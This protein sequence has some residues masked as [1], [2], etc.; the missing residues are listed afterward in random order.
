MATYPGS[1]VS[2]TTKVNKV[3]KNDADD[4]N[5]L[6]GEV[7]AI[8]TE[9]GTDVAGSYTDLKTF[10]GVCFNTQGVVVNSTGDPGSGIVGQIFYNTDANDFKVYN[11]ATWDSVAAGTG[12]I[13]TEELINTAVTEAKIAAAAIS[14]AKLKST[15]SEVSQSGS[16]NSAMGGG[17][18]GFYPQTKVTAGN[19]DA[20]ITSTA[21][22]SI[23]TTQIHLSGTTAYAKQR[24]ITSSGKEYWV[25]L[26]WDKFA[27]KVVA[28]YQ[29]PDHP[30]YG[31]PG[32]END[33]PHP[34]LDYDAAKHEV[35]LAD[36]DFLE[37]ANKRVTR[38]R[39]LLQVINEDFT[40]HMASG[41]TYKP[42]EIIE[43][44]EF[45]DKPG[46]VLEEIV[47]PDWAKTKISKDKVCL[48]RRM[49]EKLP[50]CV[51]FKKMRK[52]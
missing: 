13:G 19:Y 29:A 47:T 9:L 28:S 44:D 24:Y 23:Y 31:T 4:I 35:V 1:L 46:E 20:V 36:N 8:E 34:F 5:V 3:D 38:Q 33:V 17:E 48:K 18:Y 26:L 27:K 49:V 30:C 12:S 51:K 7:T 10:I 41:P 21:S 37:A 50:D 11:G 40:P 32:D 45:G 39:S 6:Q 42:R 2:F 14:Q 16:G 15:T 52:K 43:I 22:N 25:F